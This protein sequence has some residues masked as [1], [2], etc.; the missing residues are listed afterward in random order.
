VPRDLRI[1]PCTQDDLDLLLHA[2]SSPHARH[3]HQECFDAQGRG[4]AVYFLAWDGR[5]P[6]GMA[7]LLASSKYPE[8]NARFPGIVEINAL[9]A[10]PQGRGTGSA[11][12]RTAEEWARAEGRA[13]LGLACE[14]E[15]ARALGL[16]E[17]RGFTP[18][19]GLVVLDEWDE[20]SADGIGA[21]HADPCLYLVMG[22][23]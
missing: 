10:T 11:L 9:E 1:G 8:V 5:V 19:P 22:L 13:F 14:E 15:N 18:V 2:A 23:E 21:H 6:A 16:Y 7:T 20:Y 4:E 17:R 12:L 3:H